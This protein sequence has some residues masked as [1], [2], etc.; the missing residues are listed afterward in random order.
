[1]HRNPQPDHSLEPTQPTPTK[2]A[3]PWTALRI[4]F[5][6]R[7][8]ASGE[9]EA[10][11]ACA[12]QA[13]RLEEAGMVASLLLVSD[14]ESRLVTLLSFWDRRIF[15]PAR[16]RRVAWMEKLLAPFS[17]GAVR[18]Q[19]GVPHLF[20]ATPRTAVPAALFG[21]LGAGADLLAAH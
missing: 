18:T 14:R 15:E 1:M 9:L 5:V 13:A 2:P 4:D 19:T 17:D 12:L 7:P 6:A 20:A 3:E 11:L 8:Q 16:E 21:R 10:G